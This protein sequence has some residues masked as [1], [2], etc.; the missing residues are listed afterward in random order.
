M[1][2][3]EKASA[4]GAAKASRVF[5]DDDDLKNRQQHTT[6][7]GGE[8]QQQS[9]ADCLFDEFGGSDLLDAGLKAIKRGWKIFPCNGKKQ[10]LTTN[11]FKD[12]TTD[13]A[14][15]RG[16]VQKWPGALWGRALLEDTVVIDLDTKH[17]KNGIRE[18]ERLQGCSPDQYNAPRVRTGTG[19][20]HLYTDAAGRDFKNSSDVI[21][22]GV[23]TRTAGGY[24]I[25]PAGPDSGYRWL[26]DPDT[27]LPPT[28]Q[29]AEVVLRKGESRTKGNGAGSGNYSDAWPEGF[30]KDEL[31]KA[32]EG[33][34]N[35]GK[36]ERDKACQNHAMWI[37]H[38]AGGGAIDIE[39]ARKALIGFH[40][41]IIAAFDDGLD[42][43]ILFVPCF[44]GQ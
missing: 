14:I 15:A 31:K 34:Q 18:F 27:P 36:G 2:T 20:N 1:S 32:C 42:I 30:G 23:D 29:W 24:V 43:D 19:G 17:G 4:D 40:Q 8:K 11:G 9:T 22:E 7:N 10:P 35:A 33:I 21:A 38:L 37:G 12:A 41:E 3:H 28:P 44:H 26:S 6:T 25:I 39:E 13:E 5:D 16:W